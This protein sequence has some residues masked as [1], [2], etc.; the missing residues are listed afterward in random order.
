MSAGEPIKLD[1]LRALAATIRAAKDSYERRSLQRDYHTA[2]IS[3]VRGLLA[4]SGHQV[5]PDILCAI[6]ALYDIDGTP[7]R[8]AKLIGW[9]LHDLQE[10]LAR[11]V[12][13]MCER[14]HEPFTVAE[15]RK[16]GGYTPYG[17]G[18]GSRRQVYCADCRRRIW[19]DSS[20]VWQSQWDARRE[21]VA[22]WAS[23]DHQ[24]RNT[25]NPLR[26]SFYREHLR[27]YLVCWTSGAWT[28][29]VWGGEIDGRPAGCMLCADPDVHL[30]LTRRN[31]IDLADPF[32]ALA[33]RLDGLPREG[34]EVGVPVA[35][36]ESYHQALWR[37]APDA[38]FAYALTP[39][40]VELPLLCF[41]HPC[42]LTVA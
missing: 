24:I 15:P 30:W 17:D 31:A 34:A 20:R 16:I 5:T 4:A 3:Y 1:G 25:S 11:T 39:P 27:Q 7:S 6:D 26:L 36:F 33:R 2:A 9:R 13:L 41:C 18:L 37:L 10:A 23:G 19:E 8:L 40:L 28:R 14:C 42:Q 29:E 38:Y 12:E 21:G 35:P 32:I 22:R